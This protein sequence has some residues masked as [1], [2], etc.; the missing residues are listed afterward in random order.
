[1]KY[2]LVDVITAPQNLTLQ[3][4]AD[5]SK[6][7]RKAEFLRLEPGFY[8]DQYTD[9]DLFLKS[10]QNVTVK[11]PKTDE[12][13]AKLNASHIPYTLKRGCSCTGGKLNVIFNAVEVTK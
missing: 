4:W 11:M 7:R 8:Y 3:R 9:D 2:R 10:L 1:M 12:L 13:I 6:T 5:S